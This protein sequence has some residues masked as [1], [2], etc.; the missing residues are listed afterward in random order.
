VELHIICVLYTSVCFIPPFTAWSCPI[1][2]RP[3]RL[4]GLARPA[5]PP[6]QMFPRPP[7]PA[8]VWSGG[9]NW[10]MPSAWRAGKPQLGRA[11]W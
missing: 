4:T 1:F 7:A 5:H 9:W 2:T 11:D 3:K 8:E 10:A 6:G